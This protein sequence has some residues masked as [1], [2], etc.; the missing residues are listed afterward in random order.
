[1][2]WLAITL[3]LTMAC[4]TEGYFLHQAAPCYCYCYAVPIHAAH[5]VAPSTGQ[6]RRRAGLALRRTLPTC[7]SSALF[8]SSSTPNLLANPALFSSAHHRMRNTWA[9][10]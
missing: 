3:F 6:Q 8:S 9:T 4:Q 5:V 10:K 1:M 7:L 2:L